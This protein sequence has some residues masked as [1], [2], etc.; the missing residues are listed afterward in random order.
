MPNIKNKPVID[1]T[2]INEHYSETVAS[3]NYFLK[4]V[5]GVEPLTPEVEKEL[6]R[7]I[8]AGDEKAK[9][10]LIEAHQLFVLA[11]AKRYSS[12]L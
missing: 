10:E 6:F 12:N 4:D 2:G 3:L 9:A 5:R 1:V 11:V 8:K 7:R